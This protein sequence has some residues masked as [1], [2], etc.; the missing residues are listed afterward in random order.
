MDLLLSFK[1]YV[2]LLIYNNV[3]IC[4]YYS[5]LSPIGFHTWYKYLKEIHFNN[6]RCLRGSKNPHKISFKRPAPL[7]VT[8]L[9]DCFCQK[10]F[11]F[12]TSTSAT[13][14]V[15]FNLGYFKYF[16]TNTE[17]LADSTSW[18][19]LDGQSVVTKLIYC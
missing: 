9:G 7:S 16:E 1:I 12:V 6:K 13:K 3:Y 15:S 5:F 10:A 8:F 19:L 18:R 17:L 14:N 4:S 2:I 11:L